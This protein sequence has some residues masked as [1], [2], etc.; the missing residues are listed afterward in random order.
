MS[1]KMETTDLP[2]QT[3]MPEDV[4]SCIKKNNIWRIV[5]GAVAVVILIVVILLFVLKPWANGP[6]NNENSGTSSEEKQEDDSYPIGKP[7]VVPASSGET[8]IATV[9]LDPVHLDHACDAEAASKNVNEF[10]SPTGVVT[11]CMKWYVY[12]QD[13]NTYTMLLDHNTTPLVSWNDDNIDVP[14]E[15][16]NLVPE[17]NKLTEEYKWQFTPRLISAYEVADITGKTGFDAQ[18]TYYYLD[19]NRQGSGENP[20]PVSRYAWLIN[21]TQ[22]CKQGMSPDP[23]NPIFGCEYEETWDNGYGYYDPDLGGIA[24]A[25]PDGYWTSTPHGWINKDDGRKGVWAIIGHSSALRYDDAYIHFYGI[26][27]VIT[28]DKNIF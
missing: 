23:K 1:T 8:Y 6:Q 18:D 9:Y 27:P 12:K 19:T 28:V 17:M 14:Y 15:E 21:H 2:E 24:K 5:L 13:A 11:G 26:R 4:K 10:G 22:N 3:N 16:S 7:T 20:T 25:L